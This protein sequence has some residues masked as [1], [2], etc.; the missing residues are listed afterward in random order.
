MGVHISRIQSMELDKLGTS[1]LLLAKNIGN[2]SFNEIMEGSLPSPSP[3]PTPS[4]DMTARKEFIN[5]KYVD[6]RFSRK[7]CS[8]A[9]AKMVDLCEA[10]QSRDLLALLQVYAEGVELMEPL[11]EAGPEAGETALHFSVRTA[12]H[13]SLHLVDFLVQN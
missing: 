1:E 9:V 3:K 5:S 2:S 7:T 8:S 4:S 11:P 6:H 10:V 13:T 12:D